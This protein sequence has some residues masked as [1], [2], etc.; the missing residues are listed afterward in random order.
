MCVFVWVMESMMYILLFWCGVDDV[1]VQSLFFIIVLWPGAYCM[2]STNWCYA[3][4]V[5]LELMFLIDVANDDASNM[6]LFRDTIKKDQAHA[7]THKYIY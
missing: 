7:H 5:L 6:R 3:E 2:L 1:L 4:F